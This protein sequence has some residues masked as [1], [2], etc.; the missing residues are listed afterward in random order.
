LFIISR[1]LDHLTIFTLLCTRESIVIEVNAL[2]AAR[3]AIL[4]TA[5]LFVV[6]CTHAGTPSDTEHWEPWVYSTL[7]PG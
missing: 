4:T 2:Y 7:A 1:F 5:G 6:L 3:S